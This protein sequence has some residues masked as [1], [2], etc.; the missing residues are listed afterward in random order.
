MNPTPVVAVF[1]RHRGDVLL[2]R[3]SDAVDTYAG[4]WGTVSGYVEADPETDARREIREETALDGDDIDLVRAGDAFLVEDPDRESPWRVHPFL[5]DSATRSIDPNWEIAGV[6]WTTPGTIFDRETVPGLWEDWE[7]VRPTVETVATD[8]TH[9]SATLSIRALEVLRDEAAIAA[10]EGSGVDGVRTVARE[11]LAARPAMV[12]IQN[13]V[14]RVMADTSTEPEAKADRASGAIDRAYRTDEAAA[15]VAADLL[16]ETVA[17]LSRSGTVD[18]ALA[19][20]GPG[21]VV[22]AESRPGREGVAVAEGLAD[23][24]TVTLTTDAGFAAALD[25]HE[26]ETLVVGAD[27]VLPDGT[28]RNKVGTRNGAISAAHE[29]IPVVVV[30]ACDKIR[31]AVAVAG[32]TDDADPA[33]R[34]PEE[35]DWR[36]MRDPAEVYS[37]EAPVTV[38]NPTFDQTPADCIDAVVTER[39]PLS[40]TDIADIA[41]DHRSNRDWE[42]A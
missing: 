37:G 24:T 17:T 7:R 2:V 12:A 4:R 5:F 38:D 32:A 1:L 35:R 36:E 29:G 19:I 33:D 42:S 25:R 27:A 16:G 40:A 13:R 34:G 28:V 14:N 31:P 11:L 39:G 8:T 30:T 15:T 22:V 18:R 26:V 41:A 20:V 6:A 10:H 21:H 9:G 23:E 3:R